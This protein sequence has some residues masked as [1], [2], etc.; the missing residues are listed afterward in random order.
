[1]GRYELTFHRPIGRHMNVVPEDSRALKEAL[2]WLGYYAGQF[3]IGAYVDDEMFDGL[4]RF[5]SYD[6]FANGAS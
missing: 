3:G 1:M 5:Q 4:E 2:N 6:G